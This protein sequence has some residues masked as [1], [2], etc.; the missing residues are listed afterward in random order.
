M[1]NAHQIDLTGGESVYCINTFQM[2]KAREIYAGEGDSSIRLRGA[3]DRL[4]TE[5]SRNEL[6]AVSMLLLQRL[7]AGP[8]V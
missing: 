4:E 1:S 5:L 7:N 6:A 8:L 2:E 3:L